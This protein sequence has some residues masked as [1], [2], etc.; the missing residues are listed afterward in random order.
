MVFPVA[1]SYQF[2]TKVARI[3]CEVI[4][5]FTNKNIT[6]SFYN[7]F[8]LKHIRNQNELLMQFFELRTESTIYRIE[9]LWNAC[10]CTSIIFHWNWLQR[11]W[12]VNIPSHNM[13]TSCDLSMNIYCR[14]L[15]MKSMLMSPRIYSTIL[16]FSYLAPRSKSSNSFISIHRY[17]HLH[18]LLYPDS[19]PVL[20][21]QHLWGNTIEIIIVVRTY[22]VIRLM[23]P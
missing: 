21:F 11:K 22:S 5:K 8:P 20:I 2:S 4:K 23:F 1:I 7:K 18:V 3:S 6:D 12:G 17:K 14:L 13:K 10:K 16:A 9:G 15:H 19:K